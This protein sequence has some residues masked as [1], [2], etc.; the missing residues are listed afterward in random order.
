[1]G[2]PVAPKSRSHFIL[3]LIVLLSYHVY[4]VDSQHVKTNTQ[5]HM[6]IENTNDT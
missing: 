4:I 2:K 3:F 1:M 5:I 6:C